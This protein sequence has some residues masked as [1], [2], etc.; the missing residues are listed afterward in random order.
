MDALFFGDSCC[1]FIFQEHNFELFFPCHHFLK[2][3]KTPKNNPYILWWVAMR[4]FKFK[5]ENITTMYFGLSF[6]HNHLI[7]V[8]F[9]FQ[10]LESRLPILHNKSLLKKSDWK[11]QKCHYFIIIQ[12]TWKTCVEKLFTFYMRFNDERMFSTL[13]NHLNFAT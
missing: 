7:W 5:Y 13:Y 12:R 1:V 6:T 2:D 9:D 4:N 3:S 8:V 10:S 11:L